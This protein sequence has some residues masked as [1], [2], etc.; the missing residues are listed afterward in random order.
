VAD[1]VLQDV[2]YESSLANHFDLASNSV[3]GSWWVDEYN[4]TQFA[5]SLP[6]TDPLVARFS[7]VHEDIPIAG[8]APHVCYTDIQVGYDT[9]NVVNDL[10]VVNHGRDAVTGDAA[11]VTYGV[12]DIT[13]SANWGPRQATIDTS[14]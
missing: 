13:S 5:A 3:G 14:L 1:L 4:V 6:E 7:D 12:Q 11:D 10:T 9:T 2:V 8:A